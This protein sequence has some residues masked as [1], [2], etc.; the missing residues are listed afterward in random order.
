MSNCVPCHDVF[1]IIFFKTM[2]N[3]KLLDLVFMI[4][5]ML[6]KVELFS[7]SDGNT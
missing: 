3:K 2:Y 4:S 7:A 1:V 5:A 6:I